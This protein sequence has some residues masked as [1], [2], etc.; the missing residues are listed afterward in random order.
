MQ[1]TF[2]GLLAKIVQLLRNVHSHRLHCMT[3]LTNKSYSLFE[4]TLDVL[5]VARSG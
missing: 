5:S 3:S 1:V 4:I 2:K